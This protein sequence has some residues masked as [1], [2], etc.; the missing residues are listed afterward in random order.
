MIFTGTDFHSIK[1]VMFG[2]IDAKRLKYADVACCS[3]EVS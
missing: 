1:F 3:E 2:I